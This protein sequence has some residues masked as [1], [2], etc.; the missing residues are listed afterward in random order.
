MLQHLR[1]C[2]ERSSLLDEL[3]VAAS[4][5]SEAVLALSAAAGRTSPSQYREMQADVKVARAKAESAHCALMDHLREHGCKT[6]R[7][8]LQFDLR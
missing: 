6:E 2:P 7:D 3:V 8:G 1:L 4:S 5:Y